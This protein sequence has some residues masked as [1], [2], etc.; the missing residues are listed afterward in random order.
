MKNYIKG[1]YIESVKAYVKNRYS[2]NDLDLFIN[3]LPDKSKY[4]YNKKFLEVT[5]W[6]DADTAFYTPL[7]ILSCLHKNNYIFSLFF[8]ERK[9]SYIGLQG[10]VINP[11]QKTNNFIF[12][13]QDVGNFLVGYFLRKYCKFFFFLEDTI[14]FTNIFPLVFKLHFKTLDDTG[15]TISTIER[16]FYTKNTIT[17]EIT[18]II[19]NDIWN[20]IITGFL[21]SCFHHTGAKKIEILS[22]YN[23]EHFSYVFK[24]NW[25]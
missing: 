10:Q 24:C 8:N 14:M 13:F 12:S 7:K 25:K 23:R 17:W 6:Y 1:I 5:K 4:F 21:F 2:A 9:Y 16:N 18:N 20:K 11:N 15:L 19:E 22:K 3:A